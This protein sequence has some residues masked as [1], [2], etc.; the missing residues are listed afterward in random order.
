MDMPLAIQ[1]GITGKR[2][3]VCVDG[4]RYWRI[5]LDNTTVLGD[6]PQPLDETKGCC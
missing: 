5:Y 2:S 4:A 1:R 6:V 3:A